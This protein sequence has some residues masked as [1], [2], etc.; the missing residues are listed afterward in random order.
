MVLCTHSWPCYVFKRSGFLGVVFLRYKTDLEEVPLYTKRLPGISFF[1]FADTP[2]LVTL[3]E[4]PP[5]IASWYPQGAAFATF[6]I[7]TEHWPGLG[8]LGPHYYQV[9]RTSLSSSARLQVKLYGSRYL[10]F[11]ASTSFSWPSVCRNGVKPPK[12]ASY[13]ISSEIIMFLLSFLLIMIMFS[14][15]QD[16]SLFWLHQGLMTPISN[17]RNIPDNAEAFPYSWIFFSDDFM[18]IGGGEV[19]NY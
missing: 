12:L 13:F 10:I 9:W 2:G 1:R 15:V 3:D 6:L 17:I 8:A 19:I 18:L 7:H 16:F 14:D 11:Y 5:D 4:L